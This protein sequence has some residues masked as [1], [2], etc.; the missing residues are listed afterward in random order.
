MASA[1]CDYA[2]LL[3]LGISNYE[4]DV[5]DVGRICYEKWRHLIFGEAR[6]SVLLGLLLVFSVA[7][8]VVLAFELG[9][10]DSLLFPDLLDEG[11]HHVLVVP[12]LA[13]L[14]G[15]HVLLQRREFPGEEELALPDFGAEVF[16]SEVEVSPNIEGPHL[17]GLFIS[18]LCLL[19]SNGLLVA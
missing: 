16:Q 18:E 14:V 7:L 12:V 11:L 2:L 15:S 17:A 6:R 4:H 1:S 9:E 5:V 8:E 3:V 10:P 19:K 13:G